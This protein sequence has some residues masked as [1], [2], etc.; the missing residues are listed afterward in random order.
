[1]H[2][3][4]PYYSI[5]SLLAL[6]GLSMRTREERTVV[7][8]AGWG[9][10]LVVLVGVVLRDIQGDTWRYYMTFLQLREM[11][12]SDVWAQSD[13]NWFFDVLNWVLGQFGSNILWLILPITLF[14]ILMMRHSLHTMLGPLGT[15]MAMLL[16][17]VY[18][19]FIFYVASGM[20]Q[21]IAM[22]LLMQGYVCLWQGRRTVLI[23]LALAPMF[24]TGAA[25]VFP[26]L[27]LHLMTW[28]PGFGYGRALKLGT[29]LLVACTLLSATG[30]NQ[31]L[32]APFQAYATF[33]SNY[34]VYFSDASEVGYR[35][36]FRPD[37]TLFSFLPL[38]A[39]FWL[40]RQGNGLSTER[41]LWWL[42]LYT[43]LACIYQI[44]AF[45]PFA[46][47]F[48]SFGWFLIPTIL[49]LM[50][51]DTGSRRP[52]QI[53]LAVFTLL[54]IAILQFYTGNNLHVSF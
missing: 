40:R 8:M 48:A 19:F 50:L 17:S 53:I 15:A 44:F 12:L 39:A 11:P 23:W 38:L 31:S 30:L 52:A 9:A 47:R 10:L 43:L 35:A 3:L 34:E 16:Y 1:M 22:A 46:D 37:F 25:L 33:S 6:L 49:M 36:G 28:R 7:W 54:N 5:L 42:N 4:L 20:K 51:Q 13:N 29:G 32:L 26:F 18:P 41:S 27:L 14:C 24:H 21:A 2:A 45:A